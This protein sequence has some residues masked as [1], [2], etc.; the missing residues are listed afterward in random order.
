MIKCNK[1]LYFSVGI[2]LS[3]VVLANDADGLVDTELEKLLQLDIEELTLVNVASKR[4]EAIE[5][6][7]GII[8]VVT[9]EEIQRYGYRNLRDIL[10]RQ[11]H[12]QI[13]GSNLSPHGRISMR[14]S[15]FTHTDNTVLLLINGRPIR[16]ANSVT[17]NHDL[18]EA[19]PVETIKQMEIIRGP[20]SVLYGTNAFAG[21]I[22]IVT[23]DAPD[24]PSANLAFS[25]GSF[26]TRKA[27]LSGGGKWDDFEFFGS[28]KTFNES[29]DNFDNYIDEFGTAGTYKTGS[30]GEFAFLNAKYKEFTLN[31]FHSDSSIDNLRSTL[32][33]PASEINS[34]R[35]YIDLGYYH[36]LTINWDVSANF[37]YHHYH[38]D[39]PINAVP[40]TAVNDA[41][42]YFAEISSNLILTDELHILA[43]GSYNL[44]DGHILLGNIGFNTNTISAYLQADYWLFDWLKL[45]GGIQYNEPKQLSGDYSP[46]AGVVARLNREWGMKFMYGKAFREASPI[47]RFVNVPQLLGNPNLEPETIETF[48]AQIF[49]TGNRGSFS[50][51]YFH[52]EQE[53]IDRV[54]I[55]PQRLENLGDVTFDGFELEGKWLFGHSLSFLGNLAYQTN[56]HSDGQNDATYAPDWMVKTGL[57]YES[58]RGYTFSLF[59]SYFAASTLQNQDINP[60]VANVNPEADG[61][62]L[63]TANLDLDPGE[64]FNNQAWSRIKLSVYGDNLLDEDIFFPSISRVTVNSIPHHQGRGVY[65]TFSIDF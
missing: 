6:A 38:H 25:Y 10:D 50:A 59:N 52:S 44:L 64:F 60:S 62:N 23:K 53:L 16:D 20:G 22:N 31:A 27:N 51:T 46:R 63:L 18:Y 15:T 19:Y 2:F 7:P 29:G 40:V 56:E 4:S 17:N 11:I 3:T 14:G 45:I 49:Y 32:V 58:E 42:N 24:S 61:Y 34:E 21:V 57:S 48:D 47:E 36:R 30:E 8:T 33:F 5:D 41:D 1:Y 55:T 39:F 65:A 54:G 35:Q 43:G 12:I 28:L 13:V 37:L 26:D 9:A